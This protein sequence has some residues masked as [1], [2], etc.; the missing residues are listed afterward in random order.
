MSVDVTEPRPEHEAGWRVLWNQY[1]DGAIEP[2]V[3]DATWA[4]LLDPVSAIAGL[5]AVSAGEVVGFTNYVV[6]EGTWETKPVCYVED[7]FVSK[8]QRGRGS[9]VARAMAAQLVQRVYSGEWSRLWGI[10]A[11][12]NVVAQ[13]LYSGF[14]QGQ[15]YIRYVMR[16]DE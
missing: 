13:R 16:G 6:H 14:A 2:H 12:N 10:T 3:S 8:L 7:V 11:A 1:C 4:R 15:P 5:V 9:L